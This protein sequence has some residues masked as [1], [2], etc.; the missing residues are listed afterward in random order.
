MVRH[1][2]SEPELRQGSDPLAPDKGKRDNMTAAALVAPPRSAGRNWN[3]NLDSPTTGGTEVTQRTQHAAQ[4]VLIVAIAVVLIAGIVAYSLVAY[5]CI[6]HG[7]R[8]VVSYG[9]NGWKVWQ[10]R[11]VCSK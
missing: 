11:I 2:G 6:I 7:Y 8:R 5:Q 10:F 9:P 3:L 4:I 1:L